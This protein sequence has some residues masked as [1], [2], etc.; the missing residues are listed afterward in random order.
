LIVSS[1]LRRRESRGLHYLADYPESD[2]RAY[3]KD[4][5][6]RLSADELL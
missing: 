2:D 5:V 1:A 3:L 4:T 6:L